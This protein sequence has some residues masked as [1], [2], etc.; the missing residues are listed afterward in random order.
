MKNFIWNILAR[1]AAHPKVAQ[2]LTQRA[3]KTPYTHITSADGKD[4]YMERY[5]LFNPYDLTKES[6][7]PW[8][9][10]VRVHCIRRAD[11]DRHQHDHPWD[12]R[13]MILAG[14]YREQRDGELFTRVPGDTFTLRFGE[15]HRIVK[16]PEGG[17][18]T[19]FWTWKYRGTWG[20]KVDGTKVPYKTYLKERENGN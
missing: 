3:K 6:Q 12:A 1:T 10:S 14:C 20:F 19:L 4:V 2:Y 17:V 11:Q 5:W 7:F 15:Y 9:P 18:W 8:I 13:S 16:V